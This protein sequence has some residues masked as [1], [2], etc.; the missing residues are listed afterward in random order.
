[1]RLRGSTLRIPRLPVQPEETAMLARSG[2]RGITW[3]EAAT[4]APDVLAALASYDWPGNGS[5]LKAVLSAVHALFGAEDLRVEHVRAVVQDMGQMPASGP[6]ADGH[7]TERTIACLRHLRHV[8]EVIR[9][10]EVTVRPLI[11]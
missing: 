9:A 6:L 10:C 2:W 8:D 11:D 1:Y 7:G 3:D 5:E 4:P